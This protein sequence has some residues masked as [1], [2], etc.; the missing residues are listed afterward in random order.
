M[1]VAVTVRSYD[2]EIPPLELIGHVPYADCPLA[3]TRRHHF[4]DG[5]WAERDGYYI[6]HRPVGFQL[7][8]RV[9]DTVEAALAVIDR[10]DPTFPAWPLAR[11]GTDDAATIA[12]RYKFRVAAAE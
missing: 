9:F 12:C 1:Q 3:V 2:A 7:G 8:K 4:V 11:G 5:A 10:C 6:T